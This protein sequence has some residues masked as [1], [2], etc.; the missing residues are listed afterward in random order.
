[1][2]KFRAANVT[3]PSGFRYTVPETK[4][5]AVH[6]DLQSLVL[7]VQRHYAANK[8]PIPSDLQNRIEHAIC[9]RNPEGFCKGEYEPGD[10]QAKI[11]NVTRVKEA[12]RTL[13][14]RLKWPVER[15][16]C[17]IE[18]AASR[19]ATCVS[20]A[21][22]YRGICTTCHGLK[23]YVVAAIGSRTT[24]SD[25][26]LGVCTHCSCMVKVKV[27]M[28]KEALLVV[29]KDLTKYPEGCWLRRLA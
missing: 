9:L 25:A 20:C 8:L 10:V 29:E 15:F 19:A 6:G 27:H 23:D 4:Y 3:P 26:L 13:Q 12:S 16:L 17:S 2:R 21:D 18:E 5:E 14:T 7:V 28:S 1:M 22:N 24:P 11:I